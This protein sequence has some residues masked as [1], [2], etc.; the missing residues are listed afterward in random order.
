MIEQLFLTTPTARALYERVRRLGI[1][2]YHNHLSLADIRKNTRFTDI[3][4]LWLA[5]DPYK[6]RVMRMCGIPESHITGSAS[7]EEKF[8]AWCGVYPRLIGHPLYHWSRMELDLL[9]IGE[10]PNADNAMAIY[11]KANDYLATHEVTAQSLLAHFGVEMA[12]PCVSAGEDIAFFVDTPNLAPSLRGDDLI[13]PT[14]ELLK[15]LEELTGVTVHNEEDYRRAVCLRLDALAAVGCRFADHALDNGFCYGTDAA[16][17]R[18]LFLGREYAKRGFVLQLHIGAQRTTSTR[19]R[20][21]AGAAGGYAAIGNSV[22][23]ASLTDFLN[24]MEQAGGLPRVMLFTL[25]PA[26]NA[27][28]SVLAGSFSKD[29]CAGLI[30]QGPAW[31]WCDHKQGMTEML[32]HTA[33]YSLL[34]NFVGMTTDS[35][36]FLSFVRHDYF[37][38][39][40][41]QWIGDKIENGEYPADVEELLRAVCYQNAKQIWEEKK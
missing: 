10:T 5:P 19:L 7:K 37:R 6:H 3:Y 14:P 16:S 13:D 15:Q 26:D 25:N 41:C 11:Q 8:A 4:E 20:A 34:H 21:L 39:L 23:I 36:S 30:T 38:R 40:V 18:L 17:Q 32:E 9:D 27:A 33:V 2:D 1:I 24:D 12:C 28:L 31:W 35:R 29:G 22:D